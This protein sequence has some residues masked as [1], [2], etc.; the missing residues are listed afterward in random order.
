MSQADFERNQPCSTYAADVTNGALKVVLLMIGMAVLPAAAHAVSYEQ[1]DLLFAQTL[2]RPRDLGLTFAYV[3]ACVAVEDYEAAIG[4]LE[5]ILFYAPNNIQ[6]KTELG[7]LY[8][9]LKSHQ[10]ARQYFDAVLASP[11]ADDATRAKI[12]AVGPAIETGNTGNH[13]FGSLQTGVRYQ[14]NAGFNPD[15]NTLR[16]LG[17]DYVVA[18]PQDKGSDGNWFGS[19]S[20]GYDYDL[21]NQRGDTVE[22]RFTGYLTRQFHFTDLSVGL[23]DLSVGPRFALSESHPDWTIKPYLAGGQIWIAGARYFTSGGVGII[24]DL[25]VAPTFSLQPAVEIRYANLAG[26]SSFS[27]LN[28]GDIATAAL[29]AQATITPDISAFSRVYLTRGGADLSYQCYRTF[30][31]EVSIVAKLAAPLPGLTTTWAMSPY[32]KLLQTDF[33][34]AN[35]YIDPSQSRRDAEWQ[36]GVV[37]DTPL[38]AEVGIV[39]NIQYARDNSNIPNFRE[40]NFSVLSGPTVR[41]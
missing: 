16:L 8:Y 20:M 10:M 27:S 30:A 9:R 11:D 41:F 5:R 15:N 1:R 33:D 32:V 13:V 2:K 3:N 25:P 19:L 14:S 34:G 28:S 39:T 24:A 23:F 21:G 7:F 40:R 17:Q 6:V 36:V 37:F 12:A 18:H 38:S 22:T 26:A 35:P 31:E 4:A 29:A